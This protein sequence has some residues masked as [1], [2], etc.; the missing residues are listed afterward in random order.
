MVDLSTERTNLTPFSEE[1][2]GLFHQINTDPF[3]RRYLWDNKIISQE[4]C[5]EI[6]E[7]NQRHF[8]EEGFGLWK[9]EEYKTAKPVGYLKHVE[10]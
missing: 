1:E 2:I 7:Q 4:N 3:V 10:I 6:L 5:Q 9:V 8:R